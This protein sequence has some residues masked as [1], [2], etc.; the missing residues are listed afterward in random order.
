MATRTEIQQHLA[1]YLDGNTKL[2]EFEDWFI[3]VLWD[4]AEDTDESARS[5]GGRVH[6]LISEASRGDRSQDSLREELEALCLP[7]PFVRAEGYI[8]SSGEAVA[9]RFSRAFEDT[10]NLTSRAGLL[11]PEE[12][13]PLPVTLP[14]F[15]VMN[16]HTQFA[17][18]SL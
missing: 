18:A 5:F 7:F 12:N 10:F 13:A 11:A 2:H 17:S 16:A 9:L 4:L 3:P 15:Q 8:L 6:I 1:E 14:D